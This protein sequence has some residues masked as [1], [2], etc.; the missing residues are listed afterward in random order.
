MYEC[1][2]ALLVIQSISDVIILNLNIRFQRILS[3][4][5]P[6]FI[7]YT[8]FENRVQLWIRRCNT[9]YLTLSFN[10]P[11]YEGDIRVC[12]KNTWVLIIHVE[13]HR[14]SLHLILFT[15]RFHRLITS[16]LN[17]FLFIFRKRP[18]FKWIKTLLTR[19]VLILA[20]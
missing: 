20:F 10:W 5:C 17:C 11:F 9:I 7:Q 4:L 16:D 1:E 6:I 15:L 8:H 12:K 14:I 13:I 18:S 2:G 19:G 3:F